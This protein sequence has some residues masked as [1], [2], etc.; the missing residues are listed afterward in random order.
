MEQPADASIQVAGEVQIFVPLKG[1]VNVEEEEKRLLKEIGKIDKDVEFLSK[2][3]ENP[4]FVER[5]P[6]ELVAKEREKLAEFANKKQV[7]EESL[8]KMRRLR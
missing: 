5:A 8:V 1:L 3:L 4:S 7:L 2:K 6:A